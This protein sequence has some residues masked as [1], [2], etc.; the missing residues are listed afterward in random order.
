MWTQQLWMT[1][2]VTGVLGGSTHRCRVGPHEVRL[3]GALVGVVAAQV[4]LPAGR[5][6]AVAGLALASTAMLFR[7]NTHD[8]VRYCHE[9]FRVN[10][11]G[12]R[13]KKVECA[14]TI[15]RLVTRRCS[16]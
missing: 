5:A 16:G 8:R 15:N 13:A 6:A 1:M 7:T 4:P 9:D 11:N 3:E 14:P 2:H 12:F 10:N